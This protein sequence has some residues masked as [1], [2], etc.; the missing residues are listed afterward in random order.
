MGMHIIIGTQRHAN[1]SDQGSTC[2]A[3]H[4]SCDQQVLSL[5]L[6]HM[7][8]LL[9]RNNTDSHCIRSKPIDSGNQN[10]LKHNG[11]IAE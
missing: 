2:F 6:F 7:T 3:M 10:K 4:L 9:N 8:Q 11:K 5:L 1:C